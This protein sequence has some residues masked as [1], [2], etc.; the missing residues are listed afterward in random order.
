MP[1][2]SN[3]LARS[4]IGFAGKWLV[5]F[6][7]T[8]LALRVA[9]EPTANASYLVL[10]GYALLGRTQAIQALALSWLFTMLNPGLVPE[11][12]AGAVGRFAIIATATL[13][14]AMRSGLLGK[15]TRVGKMTLATL[16]LG[17]LIV[18]HSY[19][20]SPIPDVSILKAT[21]WTLVTATL[22]AAWG[23]LGEDERSRVVN[24][25]FGGLVA[26]LIFSLPLLSLPVGYLRNGTGF[27]G[28]LNHP[29]AFGPTMALLG[30]WAGA[31][32]LGER[33]PPWLLVLFMGACLVLVVLSEARTAGL[34]LVLGLGSAVV[35]VP[36]LS[37]QSIRKVLPGLGSRRVWLV[38][39]A[40]VVGVLFSG[41]VLTER[42]GAYIEK[43]G[44]GGGLV[45]SYETSRGGLIDDMLENIRLNPLVGSGFGIASR[46]EEMIIDR[47]PVF[48]LPSGAPI[49]KGVM[50]IQVTEELGLVGAL[51]VF[52]WLG[53]AVKRASRGTVTKLAVLLTVLLLNMGEANFFSPGGLGLLPLILFT[54]AVSVG[55]AASKE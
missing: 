4:R 12:T 38:A 9:S 18:A 10:A 50:P 2:A 48:G 24:Q 27:Q 36:F 1:A 49:E 21:S 15:R 23:A 11:A 32:M 26:V 40:A 28:I 14:V 51:F 34:A 5:L 45:Q 53:V 37:H 8:V 33:R 52:L 3:G 19:F 43:R 7:A 6:V 41:A 47:D 20:V 39:G 42:I 31:R 35:L 55:Q 44:G 46:P 17:L 16:T 30:V 25:I 29:Q 13:S 54:W 22:C